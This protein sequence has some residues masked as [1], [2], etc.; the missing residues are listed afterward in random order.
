MKDLIEQILKMARSEQKQ[1]EM[2]KDVVNKES[3]LKYLCENARQLN[4]ILLVA[5]LKDLDY[6]E[7]FET[8]MDIANYYVQHIEDKIIELDESGKHI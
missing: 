7:K 2:M 4:E 1:H 5:T 3:K 8:V 6:K